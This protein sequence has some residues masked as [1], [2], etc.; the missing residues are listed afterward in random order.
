ML[1]RRVESRGLEVDPTSVKQTLQALTRY[2]RFTHHARWNYLAPRLAKLWSY[3]VERLMA[4]AFV[5]R[6]ICD[7]DD[8]EAPPMKR[9]A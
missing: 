9:A 5:A 6:L 7:C 2:N 8:E 3:G 1:F 4:R